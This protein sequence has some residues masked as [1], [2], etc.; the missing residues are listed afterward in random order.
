MTGLLLLYVPKIRLFSLLFRFAQYFSYYKSDSRNLSFGLNFED[1]TVRLLASRLEEPDKMSEPTNVEVRVEAVIDA[2]RE[3][4]AEYVADPDT[5][6][7][8]Y[9][10]I[11]RAEWKSE[12]PLRVGSRI[13]FT[14]NFLGKKLEYT[15]EVRELVSNEKLVM[16][17]IDSPMAMNTTYLWK[18]AGPGKTHMIL[19]NR[20]AKS[21]Y[22]GFLSP[23]M[24]IAMK[25]AMTKDLN[26]LKKILEKKQ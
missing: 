26:D 18:D 11:T 5:A 19:I 4:V 15:Y 1:F 12:K 24:T 17:A 25:K 20:G 2:P 23:I 8:W 21:K 10:N 9:E 7:E 22:F 16:E 6:P 13:G 14:A 3:R